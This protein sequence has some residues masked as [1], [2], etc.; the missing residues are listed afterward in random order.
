MVGIMGVRLKR[1]R[2]MRVEWGVGRDRIKRGGFGVVMDLLRVLKRELRGL[3]CFGGGN[4][5]GE[6]VGRER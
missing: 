1:M 2:F 3:D 5:G 4:I 6:S